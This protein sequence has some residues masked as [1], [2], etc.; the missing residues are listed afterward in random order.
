M[1]MNVYQGGEH[2][3]SSSLRMVESFWEDSI[4]YLDYQQP[5]GYLGNL[6]ALGTESKGKAINEDKLQAAEL[7]S[8][9]EN[10]QP[11]FSSPLGEF[12]KSFSWASEVKRRNVGRPMMSPAQVRIA[13]KY[14]AAEKDNLV[15]AFYRGSH[16]IS[17]HA[18]VENNWVPRARPPDR[19]CEMSN[20]Y[21]EWA[22]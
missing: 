2:V 22:P 8:L 16:Q 12:L 3:K 10:D 14:R 1:V 18:W 5:G 9:M 19:A 7:V 4:T 17:R 20:W 11:D 6:Q 21:M 13:R 15:V